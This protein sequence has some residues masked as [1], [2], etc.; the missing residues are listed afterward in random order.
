MRCIKLTKLAI[1]GGR[2]IDWPEGVHEFEAI[3]RASRNYMAFVG[4]DD[5]DGRLR[6]LQLTAFEIALEQI[7]QAREEA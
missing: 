6:V 1:V 2:E 4:Q 3:R 7:S 5:R